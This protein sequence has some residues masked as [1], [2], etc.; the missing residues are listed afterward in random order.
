MADDGG[1][2]TACRL[3]GLAPDIARDLRILIFLVIYV[4][5]VSIDDPIHLNG[6]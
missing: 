5:L 1:G 6:V 4:Y 2:I 3:Y